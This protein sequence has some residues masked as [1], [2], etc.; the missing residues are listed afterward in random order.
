MLNE[1]DKTQEPSSICTTESEKV[2]EVV[3]TQ[4]EKSALDK[5]TEERDNYLNL[6][7]RTQ[8]DFDNYQKRSLREAE[9]ER[10]YAQRPL[11]LEILPTLDNF[12]RFLQSMKDENELTKGIAMMHKLLL[13]ALGRHG[14]RKMVCVDQP[15]D[16]NLH[17]AI[18]EQPSEK[19][20]G[21][22]LLE[23][24]AGYTYHDRVLR[25]AKVIVAKTAEDANQG[26]DKT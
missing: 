25:P 24:E 9:I 12:E 4:A 22:I 15:F 16:P 26:S 5:L 23:A 19:P 18:L 3:E 14:I 2:I 8:A 1:K 7:R 10:K 20:T 21:T 17:Q 11:A 6:L 13:D